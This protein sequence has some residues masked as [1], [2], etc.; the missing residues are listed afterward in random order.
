[1]RVEILLEEPSMENFLR[2]ILPKILPEGFKLDENCFL[3]PHNGKGDLMKSI[4]NKIRVF[5]NF[6]EP[7]KIIILHDQ[8]ASDCVFL[9][10]NILN[11]CQSNG[12]CPVLVRIICRELESWYLGDMTAIEK[13]YPKFKAK[14]FQRKKKFRNPDS[15]NAFDELKKIIPEIQKG[16]ASKNIPLY[17]N[18]DNNNSISFQQFVTGLNKFLK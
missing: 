12:N 6:H 17:L 9:K 3:R 10:R 7:V 11:L 13:V 8:D 15:C 18:I 2:I 16:Y 4:P 5:S 14:N 1:M